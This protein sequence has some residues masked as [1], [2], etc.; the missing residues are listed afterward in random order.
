MDDDYTLAAAL[1]R[2]AGELAARMRRD[3]LRVEHKTSVSDVVSAAD[4]AAEALIE[5]RLREL[6]P[7]DGMVGEEGTARPAERTW[8]VDPVD[9]TYNFVSGLPWWCSAV[10]LTDAAGPVLG[11]VYHPTADELWLGGRDRP[12]TCN[13]IEVPRLTDRPL[14]AVSVASYLHPAT[15]PDAAARVPLLRAIGGAATVRM[16]GSGSIEL[17]A[18]AGGR[19]GAWIQLDSLDWDWLPGVALVRAAGGTTEVL[20]QSGHRWHIAGAASVVAELAAAVAG[21]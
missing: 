10:A 5:Q 20:E 13:G 6:R 14:A 4:H 19:L 2:D 1:V 12:T 11:A 17:A 8:F 7:G 21:D 16:L 3:G 18:V 9:G 15:L